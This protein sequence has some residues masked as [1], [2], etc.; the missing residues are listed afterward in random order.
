VRTDLS[1]LQVIEDEV[2]AEVVRAITFHYE[3]SARQILKNENQNPNF[4]QRML[5]GD[6]Y[7]CVLW[8][9]R[10]MANASGN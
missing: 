7:R 1:Q 8:A 10:F 2:Y 6:S 3:D 4:F 5:N 9:Q